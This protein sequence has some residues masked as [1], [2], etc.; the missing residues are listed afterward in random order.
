MHAL[1][2]H[3]LCLSDTVNLLTYKMLP[4]VSLYVAASLGMMSASAQ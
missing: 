2:L 3:S 4:Y 1:L